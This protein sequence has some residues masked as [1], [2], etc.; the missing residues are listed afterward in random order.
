MVDVVCP[1]CK[2][3]RDST[4]DFYWKGSEKR[5]RYCKPCM[6]DYANR[7]HQRNKSLCVSKEAK[8]D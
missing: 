4:F 1:R 8:N 5:Q 6:K 3:T 2:E 7:W